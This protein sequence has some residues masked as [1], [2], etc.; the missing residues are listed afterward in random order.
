MDKLQSG[1]CNSESVFQ[2]A[3]RA[4]F[5]AYAEVFLNVD[6][7]GRTNP[8]CLCPFHADSNPSFSISLKRNKGKCFT[9]MEAG[10]MVDLIEFT[11]VILGIAPKDAAQ[12]ICEDLGI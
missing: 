4:D 5:M 3:R 1:C 2:R 12:K 10:R 9:C 7:E 6:F 11:S 8:K